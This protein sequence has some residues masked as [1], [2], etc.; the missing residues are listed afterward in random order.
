MYRQR[1]TCFINNYPKEWLVSEVDKDPLL[2]WDLAELKTKEPWWKLIVG[3]KAL[4]PLLWEMFPGHKNLVPAYFDDPVRE[5]RNDPVA[6][7][8]AYNYTTNWVSKPLFGR[9]GAGI[10]IKQNFTKFGDV[11]AHKHF[12]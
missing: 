3:N 4:L 9:E 7:A 12:V 5:L 8:A 6:A 11:D 10:F 1:F 2:E